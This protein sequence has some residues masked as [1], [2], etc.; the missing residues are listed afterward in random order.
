MHLYTCSLSLRDNVCSTYTHIFKWRKSA[1]IAVIAQTNQALIS[2][3]VIDLVSF[4]FSVLPYLNISLFL[5]AC[6][7]LVYSYSLLPNS[8]Y[9]PVPL[10]MYLLPLLTSRNLTLHFQSIHLSS[11]WPSNVYLRGMSGQCDIHFLQCGST[12]PQAVCEIYILCR[13]LKHCVDL[14]P[15]VVD[16]ELTGGVCDHV[17]H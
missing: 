15:K 9:T 17:M 8:I 2:H 14:C 4:F 7:Q 13:G 6:L 1:S 10:Q 3:L 16:L 5:S 12:H 11:E